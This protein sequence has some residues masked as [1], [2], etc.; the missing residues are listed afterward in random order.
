MPRWH[1][2]MIVAQKALASLIANQTVALIFAASGSATGELPSFPRLVQLIHF[3][4]I[5]DTQL[6]ACLE[7]PVC[8]P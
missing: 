4:A 3:G 8:L 5:G 6:T 7:K 1:I 2:N